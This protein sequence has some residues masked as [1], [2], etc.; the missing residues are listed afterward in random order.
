MNSMGDI[1]NQQ[2]PKK[3]IGHLQRIST[4]NSLVLFWKNIMETFVTRASRGFASS[5]AKY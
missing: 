1:D 3:E 5:F 2:T 4:T